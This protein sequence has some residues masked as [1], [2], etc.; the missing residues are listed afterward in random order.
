MKRCHHELKP[1]DNPIKLSLRVEPK[2]DR[3]VPTA[4]IP[5]FHQRKLVMSEVYSLRDALSI[6]RVSQ[7]KSSV[8]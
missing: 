1:F 8:P 6:K 5:K 3:P 7:S 2:A 4:E